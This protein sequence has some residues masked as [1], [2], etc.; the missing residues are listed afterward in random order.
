MSV[1]LVIVYEPQD[2]RP[3]SVAKVPDR[4]LLLSAARAAIDQA[5]VQAD[6]LA[7]VDAG[8]GIVQR[9]EAERLRRLLGLLIPEL[10]GRNGQG[11]RLLPTNGGHSE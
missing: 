5:E 7:G 10:A 2:G 6:V 9:E 3:L 8:L 4:E 1:E 11:L